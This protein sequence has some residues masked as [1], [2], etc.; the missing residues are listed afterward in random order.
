MNNITMK[1]SLLLIILSA[2]LIGF[3][4]PPHT[5]NDLQKLGLK[6]SVKNLI[7]T[8]YKAVKQGDQLLKDT[9]II[10]RS[11]K[12]NKE[13]YETESKYHQNGEL[14][15][16]QEYIFGSQGEPLRMKQYDKN[17]KL[18]LAVDFQ[19][20]TNGRKSNAKYRYLDQSQYYA[21]DRHSEMLVEVYDMK[22][23]TDVRYTYN[24][25]GL[26]TDEEYYYDN[27]ALMYKN[28]YRYDYKG[29]RSETV[30]FNAFERTSW[31]KKFKYD[32]DGRLIKSSLYISNRIAVESTFTYS[33]DSIGNWVNR[34][35]EREVHKN[36]LTEHIEEGPYI[37]ERVIVYYRQ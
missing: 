19:Y 26:L 37:T 16:S 29:N 30:H 32:R 2:F 36:I 7:E 24:F 14:F 27:G 10:Y 15:Y 18:H 34:T 31:L 33:F 17:G 4:I 21:E 6:G 8:K 35:E 11:M 20:D 13:G 28:L 22:L 3:T 9:A 5:I 23:F 1:Q 12:F 25:D